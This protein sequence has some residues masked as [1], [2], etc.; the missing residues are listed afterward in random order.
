MLATTVTSLVGREWRWWQGTNNNEALAKYEITNA[1]HSPQNL[2]T[3]TRTVR[4][5]DSSNIYTAEW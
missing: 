2:L 1:A 3:Y 4:G 5:I